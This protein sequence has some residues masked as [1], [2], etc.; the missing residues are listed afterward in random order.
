VLW[1]S[2]GVA[3][4]TAPNNQN[5]AKI[6]YVAGNAF[7]VWSDNRNAS[8]DIYAQTLDPNGVALWTANGVPVCDTPDGQSV[9]IV[10]STG[11]GTATVV[12]VDQRNGIGNNDLYAQRMN[13]SG[14]RMWATGGVPICIDPATLGEAAIVSDGAGG[15]IVCWLDYRSGAGG[16]VYGQRIDANGNVLWQANGVRLCGVPS[17]K[18]GPVLVPDFSNGVIAAWPDRRTGAFDV[19]AGH[20]RGMFGTVDVPARSVAAFHLALLSSNPAHGLARF[21]FDLP[22][23]G[24]AR[25]DVIDLLGRKVRTL[26]D[27]P[28]FSAGSHVLSWDGRDESGT[29]AHAGM[30]FVIARAGSETRVA[31]LVQVR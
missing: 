9:P 16:E 29:A 27:E 3:V 20:A 21:A 18:Y 17:I 1:A 31:K 15:A 26:V 30:Y 10:L 6:A 23:S 5:G 22:R 28:E 13:A 2:N 19:Y 25:A 24:P 7:I 8:S 14:A 11:N 12:W 4:C